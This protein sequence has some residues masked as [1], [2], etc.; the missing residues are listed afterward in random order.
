MPEA[1]NPETLLG[2]Q[3]DVI[4]DAERAGPRLERC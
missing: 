2:G 3:A 4:D 1:I